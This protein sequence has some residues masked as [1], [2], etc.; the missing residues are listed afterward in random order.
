MRTMSIESSLTVGHTKYLFKSLIAVFP[1]LSECICTNDYW[2]CKTAKFYRYILFYS[3][4]IQLSFTRP[5]YPKS[6]PG[7]IIRQ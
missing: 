6:R 1:V 5:R 4:Y 7:G 3:E 2:K